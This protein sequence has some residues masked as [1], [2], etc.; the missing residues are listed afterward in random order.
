M[1]VRQ[2]VDD[3]PLIRLR[4]DTAAVELHHVRRIGQPNL[5]E[6]LVAEPRS[7]FV[8]AVRN[9]FLSLTFSFLGGM[10]Y[11]RAISRAWRRLAAFSGV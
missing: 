7:Q 6:Q 5:A 2:R 10:P 8:R 1:F 3:R 4:D 9:T 11:F